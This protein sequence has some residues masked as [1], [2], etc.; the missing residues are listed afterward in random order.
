MKGL[1]TTNTLQLDKM[2]LAELFE[3]MKGRFIV[4]LN[5]FKWQCQ[6]CG[7]C[8]NGYDNRILIPDNLRK[9][10]ENKC[11]YV[12]DNGKCLIYENRPLFCRANPF[13][14]YVHGKYKY[15]LVYEHCNGHGKGEKWTEQE[16]NA[17][18]DY[19]MDLQHK[20]WHDKI[21]ADRVLETPI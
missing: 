4:V 5:D 14:I 20:H 13:S 2:Q 8:C 18:M 7:K 16:Y 10:S 11:K 15:L 21:S 6:Q 3:A 1:R 19:L 17:M 9:E 12:A